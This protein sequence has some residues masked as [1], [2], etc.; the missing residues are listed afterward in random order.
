MLV[1]IRVLYWLFEKYFVD[2]VELKINKILKSLWLYKF[3]VK[4]VIIFKL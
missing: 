2:L 3:V 4:L 1:V